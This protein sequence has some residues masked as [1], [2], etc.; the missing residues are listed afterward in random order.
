MAQGHRFDPTVLRE[1]DIRGIVGDTLHAADAHALGRTF[2]SIVG[3][4]GGSRV[5]VG[6]DGRLTSPEFADALIDGLRKSGV[7]VIRIGLGPTPMLYFASKVLGADGGIMITGSHNPAEYNGFKIVLG[8]GP[9]WGESIQMLGERAAK[10][11]WRSGEGG[12]EEVE[13]LDRYVDRLLADCRI[14]RTLRIA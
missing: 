9:F 6:Y 1:Y 7:S 13:V 11:D 10:G 14:E 12:L 5:C 3:E 2:G 8:N 4:K